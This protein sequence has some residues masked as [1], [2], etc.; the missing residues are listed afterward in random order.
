MLLTFLELEH[1]L[2]RFL[3]KRVRSVSVA[4]DL[5][6]ELFLRIQGAPPKSGAIRNER[7]YLFAIATNIA[8]DYL[9]AEKRFADTL[10]TCRAIGR[11]SEDLTPE[12]YVL[13]RAEVE[14]ISCELNGLPERARASFFMCRLDGCSQKDVAETLG[15]SIGT[16]YN[17]LKLAM[18]TMADARRQFRGDIPASKSTG[19]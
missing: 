5:S 14:F 2:R 17:D 9:R 4:S 3:S 13:S 8:T 12:R 11:G 6:Q 19:R 10:A 7:A 15:V 1:E 18:H 16:V